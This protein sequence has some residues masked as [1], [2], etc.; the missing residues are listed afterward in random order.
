MILRLADIAR[1]SVVEL[2]AALIDLGPGPGRI[3]LLAEDQTVLAVMHFSKPSMS[4]I[5][6]G[7]L[8]FGPITQ[9][10][11]RSTGRAVAAHICDANGA[12]VFS[13]DVSD[14]MGDAV[15][16]LSDDRIEAGKPVSINTF[17]LSMQ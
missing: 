7:T 13:C 11:A 14:Y 8:T 16:K 6:D 15:M 12:E 5:Q 3:E 4:T 9:D 1:N 17:T 10:N 2:V